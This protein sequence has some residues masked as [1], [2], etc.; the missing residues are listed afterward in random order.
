MFTYTSVLGIMVSQQQQSAQPTVVTVVQPPGGAAVVCE[1]PPPG[2]AQVSHAVS[3][4]TA[5]L[6]LTIQFFKTRILLGFF[7]IDTNTM[8]VVVLENGLK[9]NCLPRLTGSIV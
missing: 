1:P 7:Q 5:T 2:Q 4:V 9:T 6:I 8:V 3:L